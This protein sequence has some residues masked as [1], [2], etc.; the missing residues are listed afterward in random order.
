M[1]ALATVVVTLLASTVA[2]ASDGAALFAKY[3]AMCHQTG[4]IGLP[5]QFPRLA[6]R[7]GRISRDPAGRNYL[8]D[9]VSYGMAGQITV[10][11]DSIIGVMPPLQLS[12]DDAAGVLSYVASIGSASRAKITPAEVAAA[13]ARPSRSSAD[14]HAE[15]QALQN[16]G[17]LD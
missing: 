15:R 5:G 11:N 1:P 13:R 17:I 12:N 14:V 2:R 16:A 8:I 6:G 3:C 10:D 4:A 7:V 9:V